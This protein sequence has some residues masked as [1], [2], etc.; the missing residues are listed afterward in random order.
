MKKRKKRR[1]SS[2]RT[3][4][5]CGL[6][7]SLCAGTIY[8]FSEDSRIQ[9]LACSGN[10][11][12][13]SQE[14]YA[15]AGV[16]RN[17]R[18]LFNPTSEMEN[19]LEENPFIESA[20]VS[21]EGKTISIDVS[22]KTI[23]GYYTDAEGTRFLLSD[24]STLPIEEQSEIRK[25]IHVPMLVDLTED[26]RSQLARQVSR[27]PAQMTKEVLEKIAEIVPWQESYDEKM[28][29]LTMQDGNEVFTTME[30]LPMIGGYQDIL[31]GLQGETACLLLDVDNSVIDQIAC[32]DMYLSSEEKDAR[33]TRQLEEQARAEQEKKKQE[34]EKKEQEEKEKDKEENSEKK[35][36]ADSAASS[37]QTASED[38]KQTEEEQPE[39]Q[40]VEA[41]DW[42]DSDYSWLYYSPSTGVYRSKYADVQYIY[43]ETMG[44]FSE[45]K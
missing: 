36:G 40:R 41:D 31:S 34:Q 33:R 21:L 15:L 12:F 8:F 32:S 3:G 16:S 27:Y 25:M 44:M 35:D 24:G 19:R 30:N 38:E 18:M 6:L 42:Q 9:A 23:V 4:L 39:S 5:I 14:I 7:F 28:L 13:T 17:T 45:L 37:E 1:P 2:S 22:E 43:D 20:S 10:Y 11:Y 29:K 26:Q